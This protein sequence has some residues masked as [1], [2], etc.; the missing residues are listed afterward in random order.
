MKKILQ[1]KYIYL[2]VLTIL[3]HGNI[4]SQN[5]AEEF[6]A[7]NCVSC[8][9]IGGGRLAGPDLKNVQ[10]RKNSDWLEKFIVNPQS[11]IN[12]GDVYALKLLKEARGVVMPKIAKMDPSMARALLK[13]IKE[14]SQKEKSRFAGSTIAD[15]PL[16]DEDY[17]IGRALFLGTTQLKNSGPSCISCHLAAGEGFL[18][19]GHLGPDLTQAYGRLGGKTAAAAWLANPAS[20][21]M[22]P[23][24]KKHPIDENEVLPLV[25]FLKNKAEGNEKVSDVHNFNFMIFGFIGLA[26]ILVLFDLAWGGRL[27][28]VRKPM[29]RG[30]L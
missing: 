28:A 21:T 11:A 19:G 30:E 1:P 10:D 25:A 24:Y 15:R 26:L 17:Q 3:I 27:K 29:V 9:T 6:F 7:N 8:H 23:I 18:G 20:A 12:S 14:E 16:T 5:N 4:F 2:F 13:F 22:S